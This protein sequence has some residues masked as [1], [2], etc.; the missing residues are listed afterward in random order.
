MAREGFSM[1]KNSIILNLKV[2]NESTGAR[3]KELCRAAD[4]VYKETGAPLIVCPPLASVMLAQTLEVPVFAQHTDL[5]EPGQH[6]GYLTMESLKAVGVKGSILNHAEHRVD[7]KHID[8]VIARAK[9]VGFELCVCTQTIP[10]VNHVA[11]QG[12]SAVAVE[13]PDLIGSGISVSTVRPDITRDW[14]AAVK[15]ANPKCLAIV[16][17]GVST[18]ADYAN[19]LKLGG[20]GVIL[21]SAFVKAKDPVAWLMDMVAIVARK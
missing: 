1:E 5:M 10:E 21:A 4:K 8:W 13:A 12:P 3:A 7:D 2:Y 18:P 17:A 11:P 6:T 15:K 19:A 20:E 9:Q 14:M 16:G